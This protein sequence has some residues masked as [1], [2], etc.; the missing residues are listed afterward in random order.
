MDDK[1]NGKRQLY[2]ETD[3]KR[4]KERQVQLTVGRGFV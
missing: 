3:R 1:E 2:R 4:E